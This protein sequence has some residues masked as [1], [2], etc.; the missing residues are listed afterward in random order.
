MTNS[1]MLLGNWDFGLRS[2]FM[3]NGHRAGT[4]R[5]GWIELENCSWNYEVYESWGL[6][7]LSLESMLSGI[8]TVS[9]A[10]SNRVSSRMESLL[11]NTLYL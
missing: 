2:I 6:D 8:Y 5:T 10:M 3:G 1:V 11:P 9:G 7:E 4:L